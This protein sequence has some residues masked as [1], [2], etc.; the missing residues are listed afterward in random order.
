M[1]YKTLNNKEINVLFCCLGNICR[2][3]SAHA[4]FEHKVKQAGLSDRIMVDSAGTGAWHVGES[5]DERSASTAL[6]R[7]YDLS[8]LRARQAITSDF[9]DFDYI[10]AMDSNNLRDLGSIRPESSRARLSLYLDFATGV[11]VSEVPD[12]YYDSERGFEHVLDLIENAADGLLAH[13]RRQHELA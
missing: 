7:G 11:S 2:S 10:L 8:Q 4:V 6:A 5:P 12:P 1:D 13:I 3:P 9:L